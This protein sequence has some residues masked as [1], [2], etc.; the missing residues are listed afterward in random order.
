MVYYIC[1]FPQGTIRREGEVI[2][3]RCVWPAVEEKY[4]VKT[5]RVYPRNEIEPSFI[6]DWS[7]GVFDIFFP[8]IHL[9]DDGTVKSGMFGETFFPD[10]HKNAEVIN[11]LAPVQSVD[12]CVM[13][14]NVVSHSYFLLVT[15]KSGQVWIID[16]DNYVGYHSPKRISTPYPAT[17]A[18]E[19][20]AD[21]IITVSPIV[22]AVALHEQWSKEARSF[23]R[24]LLLAMQRNFILFVEVARFT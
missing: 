13:G 23:Y 17:D 20:D 10:D 1:E 3:T 14:M 5:G 4:T 18:V 12:V 2:Y 16:Y 21:T 11:K 15:D 7:R 6:R 22:W 24:H 19:V 8:V 9:L